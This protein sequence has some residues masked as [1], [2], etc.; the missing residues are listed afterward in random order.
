MELLEASLRLS[1]Q[2][3]TLQ[4]RFGTHLGS[5]PQMGS[6]G[7]PAQQHSGTMQPSKAPV[8][9][10]HVN[11]DAASFAATRRCQRLISLC[12]RLEFCVQGKL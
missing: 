11:P 4:P 12:Y 5:C 1:A 9:V 8:T 2:E 7:M 10:P 6:L 3:Q